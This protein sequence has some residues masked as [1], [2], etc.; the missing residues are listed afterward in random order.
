[1]VWCGMVRTYA[2]T[3]W[4]DTVWYG[5]AWYGMVWCS[6]PVVDVV[7]FNVYD[8]FVNVLTCMVWY[9]MVWV[10]WWCGSICTVS[11]GIIGTVWYVGTIWYIYMVWY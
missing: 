8:G 7:L 9:C 1:M 3:V 6:M 5:A 10:D 2:D 4:Y 11:Y